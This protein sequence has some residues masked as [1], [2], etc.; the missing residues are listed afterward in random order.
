LTYLVVLSGVAVQGVAC[1]HE[2]CVLITK[3]ACTFVWGGN[4][5]GQL[6]LGAR[7]PTSRSEPTQLE[8]L[9][10]IAFSHAAAGRAHSLLL[11]VDGRAVWS[12]GAHEHG[13]LGRNVHVDAVFEDAALASSPHALPL[14][15][16]GGSTMV[17][18]GITGDRSGNVLQVLQHHDNTSQQRVVLVAAGSHHSVLITQ[19]G[20][21][22][23]WG[24]N[25]NGQVIRGFPRVLLPQNKKSGCS[26]MCRLS[27]LGY[28]DP[29]W[30]RRG[31]GWGGVVCV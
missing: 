31:V 6:G 1:G 7:T 30:Q 21:V 26:S 19:S 16:E 12:F 13:Q 18:G 17:E 4:E 25:E 10:G 28:V 15:C 14:P 11:Q 9:R 23:C 5:N 8:A 2:H 27:E 22:F 24:N 20:A 29:Q 3:D